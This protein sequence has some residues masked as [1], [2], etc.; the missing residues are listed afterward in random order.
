LR[1]ENEKLKKAIHQFTIEKNRLQDQL[2]RAFRQCLNTKKRKIAKLQQQL[3]SIFAGTGAI[4]SE[5]DSCVPPKRSKRD[6]FDDSTDDE[7]GADSDETTFDGQVGYEDDIPMPSPPNSESEIT[8]EDL[9]EP[10]PP[11][12][13]T[14]PRYSQMTATMRVT[15]NYSDDDDDDDTDDGSLTPM[16][17]GLK[18]RAEERK[19]A[20][21]EKEEEEE[22]TQL[23]EGYDL[24]DLTKD[25]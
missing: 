12:N 17:K 2:Y 15:Q 19:K 24:E 10:E 14:P 7:G 11:R 5:R 20:E 18:K 1:K 6:V 23:P 13:V 8:L 4:S 16:S 3:D 9:P 22:M 25:L 21:A